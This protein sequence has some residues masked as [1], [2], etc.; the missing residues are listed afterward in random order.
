MYLLLRSLLFLTLAFLFCSC[1]GDEISTVKN[2]HMNFDQSVTLGNVLDNCKGLE[3]RKWSKFETDLKRRVVDFTAE[4]KVNL[5]NL[6]PNYPLTRN[7]IA[8]LKEILKEPEAIFLLT[9]QFQLKQDNSFQLTYAGITLKPNVFIGDIVLPDAYKDFVN[10]GQSYSDPTDLLKQLY[11]NQEVIPYQLLHV[12]H[13]HYLD[14][15]KKIKRKRKKIIAHAYNAFQ[16]PDDL[17]K[18]RFLVYLNEEKEIILLGSVQGGVLGGA[19]SRADGVNCSFFEKGKINADGD[20]FVFNKSGCT[21]DIS[22]KDINQNGVP[23]VIDVSK[24]VNCNFCTGAEYLNGEYIVVGY[25]DIYENYGL[26]LIH[27]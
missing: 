15:K 8:A 6:T 27:I 18:V 3:N 23:L 21:P 13:V 14:K 5:N 22:L 2:G 25:L 7:D 20:K 17:G 10:R 24:T 19:F 11:E 1:T 4:I 9:L 26:S 12:I 16:C